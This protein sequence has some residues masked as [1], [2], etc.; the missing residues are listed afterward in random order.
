MPELTVSRHIGPEEKLQQ[1]CDAM[2]LDITELENEKRAIQVQIDERKLLIKG[3][4]SRLREMQSG[5]NG[6]GR[7]G[8][9][10]EIWIEEDFQNGTF[11]WS[12][13]METLA[14]EKWGIEEF[15]HCQRGACNAGLSGRDIICIMPTG[16]GKSLIYQLPAVMMSGCTLVISPLISL[17]MDQYLHLC[18]AG[19]EAMMV[20]GSSSDSKNT[21][22][23]NRL[24]SSFDPSSGIPEVKICFAT[25]E[26]INKSKRFI[27]ILQKLYD[28][29]KLARIVLD[30][31]HCV[32]QLG[33]DF[34]PDYR[35]LGR[36]RTQFSSVP[37]LCLSA[38]C[39]PSVQDDLVKILGM[40]PIGET[41]AGTGTVVFNAP[42]YRK[43]LHYTVVPK[44]SSAG[45]IIKAMA[46][47][48]GRKY[49][50]MTG[51]VYCFSKKDAETVRNGLVEASG[52]AIKAGTYHADVGDEAKERLHR[53]W[54]EGRVK[55]VC[56][57]IAFGLGD[58]K[59]V[60]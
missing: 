29:G 31:A 40:R 11:Q 30:E 4:K 38:T 24:L 54:R 48:I 15:R 47:L 55:V 50:G 9:R 46:E 19:I 16:G 23:L 12:D 35:S 44:P 42:L 39:P 22:Q 13:R 49:K 26:K 58:R 32:S 33:H 7:N 52:G 43:N 5:V 34:R 59:S 3:M 17:I 21:K 1:E 41:G 36:L 14:K 18:D 20:S 6:R 8:G 56:A 45:G 28:K 25:P 10:G 51:I 53:D 2:L 60:V 57:T 27:A 37:I